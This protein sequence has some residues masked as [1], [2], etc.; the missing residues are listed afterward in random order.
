MT[1]TL[2]LARRQGSSCK[3]RRAAPLIIFII[4]ILGV[5]SG[6]TCRCFLHQR[7][8]VTDGVERKCKWQ[9]GWVKILSTST[10]AKNMGLCENNNNNRIDLHIF[11]LTDQ[12]ITSKS[13]FAR[14]K[15]SNLVYR[16][17]KR[18]DI[19]PERSAVAEGEVEAGGHRAQGGVEWPWR[20]RSQQHIVP[21]P[22]Q[23]PWRPWLAPMGP[24]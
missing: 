14:L 4:F 15:S 10:C 20:R 5:L 12:D 22:W 9:I 16:F 3:R 23:D 11:I 19:E 2:T 6:D 8:W 18:V 1:S 24:P 7:M 13:I 21:P 17:L